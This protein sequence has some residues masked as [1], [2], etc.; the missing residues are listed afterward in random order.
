[1]RRA[2]ILWLCVPLLLVAP[3]TGWVLCV[4]LDGHLA[5]ER[6]GGRCGQPAEPTAAPLHCGA[7]LDL[8]LPAGT[9]T[10]L[11]GPLFPPDT[12]A[13]AEGEAPTPAPALRAA[14]L[15]RWRTARDPL[16]TVILRL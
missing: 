11:G 12:G 1:M 10:P 8:P 16:R 13:A 14:A 2:R 5:L 3:G 15:P 9:L 4:G 7:C 6:G